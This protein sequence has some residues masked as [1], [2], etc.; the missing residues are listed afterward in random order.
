MG[1]ADP[2]GDFVGVVDGRGEADELDVI[3]AEDD[4]LFPGGATLRI[5]Q[6][7]DLVEDDAVDVVEIPGRLQQHVAQHF[8]G[9]DDDAGIAVFGNIAGEEAD[10]VA[11]DRAQIAIFL[12]RERFDRRGVDDAAGPLECFLDAELGDHRLAGAGR[13]G[14]HDRV[15]GE[16]R[17]D[18]LALE[19]IQRK[20]IERFKLGDSV[21]KPAGIANR[22]RIRDGSGSFQEFRARCAGRCGQG[23][24][25]RRAA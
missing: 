15:A 2:G 22:S 3:G 10:F 6:I 24:T 19:L 1:A 4:R 13:R 16:Q 23:P 9:H 21:V 7:V 20:R 25:P 18:G 11:V 8:G 14:D 17:L 5:G 12:I